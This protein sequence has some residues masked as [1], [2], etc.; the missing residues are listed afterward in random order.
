MSLTKSLNT[1]ES[2]NTIPNPPTSQYRIYNGGDRVMRCA[3]YARVSTEQDSQKKSIGNQLDMFH[4]YA[5]ENDWQ[6][7]KTYTD[8]QSGTKGNRPGLKA[9]IADA[10][11][12]LFDVILAKEL[13]RLARNGGLSYELRDI[14]QANNIHIICLDNSINTIKGNV[15]NF[16]LYAWLYESESENSSRRNKAA[17]RV[18][19]GR[20]LFVGSNPPYG[21]YSDG[22]KLKIRNDNTPN[23]V[24]RIFSEYLE[25]NGM[26]AIAKN[27]TADNI[28]TPSQ[29]AKKT[30]A[31][32]LWHSSTIKNILNNKHYCGDLVQNQTETISVTSIKRR[33]VDE[34]NVTTQEN[35]HEPIIS[36]ETFDTVAKLLK[37]KTRTSTAPKK[38]I[39]TNVLYCENCHKG[40]WYRA[41][42]KGYRC[43][44][45]LKHSDA[46]CRNR[47]VIRE[48]ELIHVI[49]ED[50]QQVF[51][52]IQDDTYIKNIQ[53]KL[54]K[55]KL[56]IQK[57]ITIV[58]NEIKDCR[59]RKK[60]YLD[61]YADQV[62][63]REEFMDVRKLADQKI[64]ELV[65]TKTELQQKLEEC[66]NENYAV[67]LGSKLKEFLFLKD[68]TP[69]LLHTLVEKVTCNK[70]NE[71]RIHYNFLS[72]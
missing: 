12:G 71:I 57:E 22:G 8:K 61:F 38:H 30:N 13:S 16:G 69:Q 51:K 58:E 35:T 42:Q 67:D 10:K 28:P 44:G 15:Q 9:L 53:D 33:V 3:V 31:S 60:S 66:S 32:P 41:N 1:S 70:D 19:A 27:L 46:F 59:L 25:G 62:I 6:I 34:E 50:L 40:M 29:V 68:L 45:N 56:S 11:A 21:Y 37:G 23:I 48:K 24:R 4:S 49:L 55:K 39:F 65:N 36:K 5:I 64:S 72:V 47:V 7:V 43:G 20:G 14:C 52:C 26:E 63:G 18:K 17:K 54:K 2:V